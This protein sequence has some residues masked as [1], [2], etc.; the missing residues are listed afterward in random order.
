MTRD[1]WKCP[2]CGRGVS[3]DEKTCPCSGGE[4]RPYQ[5]STW[6]PPP[7]PP[8][9]GTWAT[10]RPPYI[11]TWWDPSVPITRTDGTQ[12]TYI[13]GDANSTIN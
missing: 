13:F 3:P 12:Q 5:P 6:T 8:P 2:V 7:L 9:P 11:T 10:P 1:G 4:F